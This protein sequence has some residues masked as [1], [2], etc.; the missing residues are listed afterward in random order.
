MSERDHKEIE[1]GV[2]RGDLKREL[3]R[4]EAIQAHVLRK[5][6]AYCKCDLPGS[7][8]KSQRPPSHGVCSPLC[9]EAKAMGWGE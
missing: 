5:I 8:A 9:D 1:P 6:C 7:N 3:K 2:T 4:E